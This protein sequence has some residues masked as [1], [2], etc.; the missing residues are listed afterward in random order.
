MSY[1][2][3][4]NNLPI[5]ITL[6]VILCLVA[7]IVINAFPDI[8]EKI[9]GKDSDTS[10]LSETSGDLITADTD[11]ENSEKTGEVTEN[12]E[13]T[14]VETENA[15]ITVT[16]TEK[17][18]DSTSDKEAAESETE[19]KNP[20]VTEYEASGNKQGDMSGV[21][22]IGDSRTVGIRDYSDI[23]EADYFAT[24]GMSV[25]N[26]RNEKVDVGGRGAVS[27]EVLLKS[28]SYRKIFVM[29]G[30][31]E[32]GY[33]LDAVFA[34]YKDLVSDIREIQPNTEI[35]VQANLHVVK[36]K[37][38]ASNIYNNAKIDKLNGMISTLA[39]N[40]SVFYIDVN[41]LFDD[42]NG[43]LSEKY[44]YDGSHLTG[45]YYKSWG[46]WLRER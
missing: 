3:R 11:G 37:S 16:E 4:K 38:D 10:T 43:N 18:E 31:N 13:I 14:I 25:F 41:T 22:F 42:G 21:L 19:K 6:A 7:V 44:A 29:L 34:K 39:D 5:Y 17:A 9:F 23:T 12:D 46:K 28:V 30:I 45:I 26:I 40:K 27:L 36:R 32:L 8:K 15:K 24:S 2:R 1:R 33:N 35:Y 20:P